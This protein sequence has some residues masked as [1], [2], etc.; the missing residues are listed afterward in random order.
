MA[1]TS[2]LTAIEKIP[3]VTRLRRAFARPLPS[4]SRNSLSLERFC[5][6]GAPPPPPHRPRRRRSRHRPCRLH[7]G[8]AGAPASSVRSQR[9]IPA[10]SLLPRAWMARPTAVPRSWLLTEI[11]SRP[12]MPRADPRR[13]QRADQTTVEAERSWPY[14]A[15]LRQTDLRANFQRCPNDRFRPTTSVNPAIRN[16]WKCG[17]NAAHSPSDLPAPVMGCRLE[18]C[19]SGPGRRRRRQ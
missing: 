11:A 3:T 12:Q 6:G 9:W 19:T 10:G 5:K 15:P 2:R 1:S 17:L 4:T 13:A 18:W 16:K 8:G 7:H 14:A